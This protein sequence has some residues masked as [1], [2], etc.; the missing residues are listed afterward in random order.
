MITKNKPGRSEKYL[1]YIRS[2][3]CCVCQARPAEPHH[4]ARGGTSVKGSDFSAIP[5]CRGHH[6]EVGDSG[7]ET[8]QRENNISIAIAVAKHLITWAD[9]NWADKEK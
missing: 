1:D 8:F 4:T 5:M 3:P 7:V 9:E 6:R 2:R